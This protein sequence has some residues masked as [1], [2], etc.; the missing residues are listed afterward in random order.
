MAPA[1]E[2]LDVVAHRLDVHPRTL[3]RLVADGEIRAYRVGRQLRFD[4][5]DVEAF[6]RTRV[7]A[8]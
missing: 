8:S 4:P 2:S 7:V 1:L 5:A 6:L 3:R